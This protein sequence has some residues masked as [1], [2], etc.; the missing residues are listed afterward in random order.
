MSDNHVQ[1]LRQFS[2]YPQMR[3]KQGFASR[4][5]FLLKDERLGGGG[6]AFG[7]LG[8]KNNPSGLNAPHFHPFWTLNNI[9]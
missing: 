3:A 9:A 8:S 7:S 4:V 5:V 2:M 6:I 1:Q